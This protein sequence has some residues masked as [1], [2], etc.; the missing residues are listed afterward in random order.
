MFYLVI[1]YTSASNMRFSQ[2]NNAILLAGES[3]KT[4][5]GNNFLGNGLYGVKNI[6]KPSKK[7]ISNKIFL[8]DIINEPEAERR[9]NKDN[10]IFML[11]G[12]PKFI[13][14]NSFVGAL[15]NSPV[16]KEM[17]PQLSQ[18]NPLHPR[19]SSSNIPA[20]P[21]CGNRDC[22]SPPP[23]MHQTEPSPQPG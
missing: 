6:F 2:V 11:K 13:R 7:V 14:E 21:I 15:S 12:L 18:K 1:R 4:L 16:V 9:S 17:L 10:D 22:P 23:P 3:S 19:S 5:F 20:I 8:H